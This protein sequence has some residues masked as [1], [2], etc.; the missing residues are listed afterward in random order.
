MARV[1]SRSDNRVERLTREYGPLMEGKRPTLVPALNLEP[2]LSGEALSSC[3]E[4]W[5]AWGLASGRLPF[6]GGILER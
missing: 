3:A 6:P 5:V 2:V 4:G 1:K